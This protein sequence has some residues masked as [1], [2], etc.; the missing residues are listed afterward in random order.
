MQQ[1]FR[2]YVEKRPGFAVEAEGL[3]RDLADHLHLDLEQVRIFVRYDVEGIDQETYFKARDTIF[4]EPNQDTVYEETCRRWMAGLS[5]GW[6]L[7]PASTTSGP[8]ARPSA[9]R[10]YLRA[11]RR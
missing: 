11:R 10:F 2:V 7:C 5:L 9:S 1:I 6:N 4:S 8:T 3:K